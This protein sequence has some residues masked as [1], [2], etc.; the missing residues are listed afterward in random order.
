MFQLLRF[1]SHFFYRRFKDKT[2]TDLSGEFG[3]EKSYEIKSRSMAFNFPQISGHF[4]IL[5][6]VL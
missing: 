4:C 5:L 1:Y 2:L 3:V 6:A